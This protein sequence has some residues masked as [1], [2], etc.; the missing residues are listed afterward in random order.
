MVVMT[1]CATFLTNSSNIDWT[2][3]FVMAKPLAVETPQRVWHI[4]V[5]RYNAV[6]DF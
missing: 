5:Y 4:H 1:S 6:K 3:T 2:V